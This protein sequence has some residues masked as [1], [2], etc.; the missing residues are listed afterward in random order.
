MTQVAGSGIAE[1]PETRG[2]R[3][4]SKPESAAKSTEEIA[5]PPEATIVTKLDPL[6]PDKDPIKAVPSL[7]VAVTVAGPEV[8]RFAMKSLKVCPGEDTL[9]SVTLLPPVV[10]MAA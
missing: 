6:P 8:I 2:C 5:S 3:K 9:I 10:E 4:L 7:P 1:T